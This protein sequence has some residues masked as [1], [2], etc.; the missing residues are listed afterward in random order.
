MKHVR[1]AQEVAI[2]RTFLEF[3]LVG[4]R[5]VEKHAPRSLGTD[6][7]NRTTVEPL[8]SMFCKGSEGECH[9]SQ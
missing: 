9:S 2:K 6:L 3:L 4:A 1:G 7:R 8:T 5:D